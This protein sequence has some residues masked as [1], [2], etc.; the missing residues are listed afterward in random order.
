MTNTIEQLKKVVAVLESRHVSQV[1]V[2]FTDESNGIRYYTA[3]TH[4]GFEQHKYAVRMQD[5]FNGETNEMERYFACDCR[6]G[7]RKML[8]RHALKVAQVEADNLG[9]PLYV[10]TVAAYN[11]HRCFEK[12]L[13]QIAA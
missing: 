12:K 1:E 10:P 13:A 9:K 11:A 2:S 8:C 3:I 4:I 5:W 7:E 6:A